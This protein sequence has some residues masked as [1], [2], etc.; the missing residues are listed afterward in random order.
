MKVIR[1]FAGLAAFVVVWVM[2][3]VLLGVATRALFPGF[4][5]D[6]PILG[7]SWATLPASAL[8]VLA[9]YRVFQVLASDRQTKAAK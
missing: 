6:I 2:V 3:A 4:G 7:M 8:G 9:G 5:G 1:F